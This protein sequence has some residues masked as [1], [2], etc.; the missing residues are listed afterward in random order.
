MTTT[1]IVKTKTRNE[2]KQIGLKGQ[3]YDQVINEL[4]RLKRNGQALLDSRF[5]SQQSSDS[6]SP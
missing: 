5:A 1:I 4:I 6:S 2:L 3:T